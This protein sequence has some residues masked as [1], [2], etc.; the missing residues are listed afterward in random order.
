MNMVIYQKEGVNEVMNS[1]CIICGAGL[2][3][4]KKKGLL[5][6]SECYFITADLD[7]SDEDLQRLYTV[8]Y[9]HGEEY[10]NYVEDKE[11]IQRNFVRH[12]NKLRSKLPSSERKQLFEIGCA[13]GFFL[14]LAKGVFDHVSGIDIS[15]DAINFAR[16]KMM[17][18]V[19]AGDYLTMPPIQADIFCMWD[20]IEHLKHP[21]MYIKKISDE[22]TDGGLIALT[23]GDISSLTARIQGKNW[24]QI[25]LPT[26]LHYFSGKSLGKLLQK[27]NFEVVYVSHPG[28]FRSLDMVAYIILVVHHNQKRLYNILKKLGILRLSIYVNTFDLIFIIGRKKTQSLLAT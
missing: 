28:L 3:P 7:I 6:C 15:D 16:E 1:I 12:L 13:Y 24:R 19:A 25:H 8:D 17:L 5:Y 27:N 23:T 4:W 26:H 11:I 2:K 20:T 21:E 22:I 9:F 18:D 14:D 10:S